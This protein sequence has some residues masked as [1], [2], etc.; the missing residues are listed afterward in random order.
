MP[1]VVA[2]CRYSVLITDLMASLLDYRTPVDL[3]Q[4]VLRAAL[5]VI[6]SQAIH[7]THAEQIVTSDEFLTCAT[8]SLADLLG[9]GPINVRLF[10]IENSEPAGF[11]HLVQPQTWLCAV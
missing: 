7:W 6:P 3:V 9:A 1:E 11:Q 5:S 8:G 10:N 4:R 2:S